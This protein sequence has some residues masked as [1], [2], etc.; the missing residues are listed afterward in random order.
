MWY[1]GLVT[2]A[3]SSVLPVHRAPECQ[4]TTSRSSHRSSQR[5]FQG[6]ADQYMLAEVKEI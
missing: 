1:E 3:G 2:I 6:D 4:Q 5:P